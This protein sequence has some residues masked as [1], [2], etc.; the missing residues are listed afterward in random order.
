[1]TTMISRIYANRGRVESALA[2]LHHAGYRDVHR[3]GGDPETD[4]SAEVAAMRA[5]GLSASVAAQNAEK[6]ASGH[7]LVVVFAP[8]G[9][10]LRATQIL[11]QY[12]PVARSEA[13]AAP[14]APSL[15]RDDATPLSTALGLP[16]LARTRH[17]FESTFGISSLTSPGWFATGAFGFGRPNPAPFSSLLGL[18]L[19]A[20]GATPLSSL[21]GLSC[22]TRSATP[23]SSLLGL[24]LLSRR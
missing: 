17:P 8:F 13:A 22:L 23:L 15:G 16:V 19:L 2:E 24:P 9:K 7:V 3:F 4:P 18:P 10:A 1:M 14:T 20:Q 6:L 21:F 12:G 11:D 5:L